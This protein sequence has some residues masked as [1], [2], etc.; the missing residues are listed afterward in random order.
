MPRRRQHG[1]TRQGTPGKAY[2]NRTDLNAPKIAEFRG[3]PYGQRQQ[4]VQAQQ[5]SNAAIGQMQARRDQMTP[6]PVGPGPGQ[7][8]DLL[9]PTAKPDEP[10]TAGVPFGPGPGPDALTRMDPD[11]AVIDRL[12]MLAK[13][14]GSPS[15]L[16]LL[17]G[18]E[19]PDV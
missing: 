16:R 15:L 8:G 13:S 19:D 11:A 3:Q 5:T 6:P 10:L 4:Q 12:R 7:L 1:G 2:G 17:E 9:A 18:W 14:T